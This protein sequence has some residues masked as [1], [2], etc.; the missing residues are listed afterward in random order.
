M[1][2]VFHSRNSWLSLL[3]FSNLEAEEWE[4][5][6]QNVHISF[7]KFFFLPSLFF[8]S[9]FSWPTCPTMATIGWVCTHLSTWLPFFTHGQTWNSTLSHLCNLLTST[10]SF[11]LNKGTPSGRCVCIGIY[12]N[13]STLVFFC[14]GPL[15]W[16]LSTS[17]RSTFTTDY[18]HIITLSWSKKQ[19][20]FGWT[21]SSEGV[22]VTLFVTVLLFRSLHVVLKEMCTSYLS[23]T[24]KTNRMLIFS[25]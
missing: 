8:R 12:P 11:F 24:L 25:F 19:W 16:G 1:I 13:L 10:S 3:W 18:E 6:I 20:N 14:P 15:L 22:Y 9:V 17:E 2:F 21:D 7:L 4:C 23:F 5:K